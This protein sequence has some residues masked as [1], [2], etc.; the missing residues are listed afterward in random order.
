[1]ASC[2]LLIDYDGADLVDA[3]SRDYMMTKNT[4]AKMH[5]PY[6]QFASTLQQSSLHASKIA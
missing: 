2:A 5:K 6:L 4:M 1:M 3:G